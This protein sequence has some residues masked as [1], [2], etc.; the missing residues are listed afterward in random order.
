MDRIQ[1]QLNK[2]LKEIIAAVKQKDYAT[3]EAYLS[4][5]LELITLANAEEIN[6]KYFPND[7]K[8]LISS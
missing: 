6:N 2:N 1:Q 8:A 4:R 7:I 5:C 3:A